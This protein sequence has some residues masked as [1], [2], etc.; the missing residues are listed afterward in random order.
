MSIF[1]QCYSSNGSTE[2][3]TTN[4]QEYIYSREFSK[5]IEFT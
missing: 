2:T 4:N 3:A 1:R 5:V